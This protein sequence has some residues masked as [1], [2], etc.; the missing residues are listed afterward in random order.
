[1]RGGTRLVDHMCWSTGGYVRR[2]GL[3]V[4]RFVEQDY[5][6]GGS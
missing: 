6:R 4:E 5:E 2:V 1:M 3:R